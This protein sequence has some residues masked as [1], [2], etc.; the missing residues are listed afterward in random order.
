LLD[1]AVLYRFALEFNFGLEAVYARGGKPSLL[2]SLRGF[3][4]AA[5][6]SSWIVMID[7]DRD[8]E[9][10]PMASAVW[11]PKPSDGMMFNIVVRGLESWLMADREALSDFFSIPKKLIPLAPEL[12]DRP[13]LVMVNLMRKSSRSDIRR[14]MIPHEGSGREVG[15]G[16]TSFLQEYIGKVGNRN[17]AYWNPHRAAKASESL[18][19][20]LD[21]LQRQFNT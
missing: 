2:K 18:S 6:H 19:R 10:A 16:Y 13:K 11:L 8:F 17:V 1:E 21:R 3:N 12:E 14:E 4:Q 20:C 15:R 9:C 5:I 7:L